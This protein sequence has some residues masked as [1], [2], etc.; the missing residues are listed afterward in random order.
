MSIGRRLLPWVTAIASAATMATVLSRTASAECPYLPPYP[1]ATVAAP[2][3]RELLVGTVIENV[4]GQFADFRLRIDRVIRGP[5]RVGEIRRIT[6]LFPGWPL[7]R[8]TDGTVISPCQP[9]YASVGDVVALAFDAVAPDGRSR[10]NA[11]SWI[12]GSAAFRQAGEYE[13]TTI[14]ELETAAQL[15]AT[16]TIRT[17]RDSPDNR[18]LQA[19]AI[20]AAAG[21]AAALLVGRRSSK[22]REAG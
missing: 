15:P 13:M 9:I 17:D 16:D 11:V 10:Y 4:D 21:V 8:T 19:E 20:V 18:S 3:A 1:A 14:P 12:S 5:A 2:S 6:S 22:G 7:D